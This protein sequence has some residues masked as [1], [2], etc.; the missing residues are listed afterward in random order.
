MHYYKRNIGDYHKK[1]GRL[2]ILEHGAYTLLLDS[3]YDRERFPTRDEAIEWCWAKTADE[4]AAIDFVLSRF[5]TIIDGV[6]VQSRIADEVGAYQ[7]N[8]STNKDIAIKRE[9]KRRTK[10]HEPCT[11]AHEP[12]PNQ[13][14]RTTNQ[15]PETSNQLVIAAQGCTAVAIAPATKSKTTGSRLDTNWQLPRQLGEW[16]LGEGLT[17]QQIRLE[18]DK[19]R[20]HWIAQAGA[21]GRKADWP[22][23]WRNWIRNSKSG[24][25]KTFYER[26]RDAKERDAD[27]RLT[28]LSNATPEELKQLGLA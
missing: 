21:K 14:P 26:T 13:E 7:K 23:T 27:K 15:E 19:F 16:A 17:E 10:K 28:A 18:A 6:Y 4:I 11:V 9:E 20:D 22:A 24:S 8:C 5:F 12:P 2:S 3:C 25:G 1:A